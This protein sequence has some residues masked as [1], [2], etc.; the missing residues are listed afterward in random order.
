MNA[1]TKRPLE[2]GPIHFVGIGGIGMPGIA[3][4]NSTFSIVSPRV[5]PRASEPSDSDRGTAESAS[6][7]KDEMNGISMIAMQTPAA[8]AVFGDTG[9]PSEAPVSRRNGATTRIAKKP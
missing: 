2:L 6:S 3:E 8:N 7:A 5:A 4:G 9:R 1:A